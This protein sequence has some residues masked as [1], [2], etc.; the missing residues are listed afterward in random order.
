MLSPPELIGKLLTT[1]RVHVAAWLVEPAPAHI[2]SHPHSGGICNS[3]YQSSV[4]ADSCVVTFH[5]ALLMD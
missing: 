2:A 3:D 1:H 4:N 5:I